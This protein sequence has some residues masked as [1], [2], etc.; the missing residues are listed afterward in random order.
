MDEQKGPSPE[1][2]DLFWKKVYVVVMIT[3]VIVISALGA[4]SRYFR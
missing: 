4:F 2:P 3:T 1:M